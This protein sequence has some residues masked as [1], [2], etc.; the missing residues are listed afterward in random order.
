[1]IA[2]QVRNEIIRRIVIE[3]NE[4]A[5]RAGIV[6]EVGWQGFPDMKG[7]VFAGYGEDNFHNCFR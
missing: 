1:M 4:P 3:Q 6:R 7:A 2:P 5:A